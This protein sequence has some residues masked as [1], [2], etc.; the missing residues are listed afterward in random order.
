MS[1]SPNLRA[2][3]ATTDK[4][5]LRLR[6]DNKTSDWRLPSGILEQRTRGKKKTKVGDAIFNEDAGDE[7][8][9][10]S[11]V[12]LNATAAR[13]GG[14]VAAMEAVND[15]QTRAILELRCVRGLLE[16]TSKCG[17]CG[18]GVNIEFKHCCIN[19]YVNMT[20]INSESGCTWRDSSALR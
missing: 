2:W 10:L 15:D 19:S 20:C 18:S 1:V 9:V 13:P 12:D 3:K 8:T 17:K 16:K 6:S 11:P 14:G 4:E 5:L 7:N